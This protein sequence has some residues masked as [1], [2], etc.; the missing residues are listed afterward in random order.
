MVI[1]DKTFTVAGSRERV[2]DYLTKALMRSIPFE[3]IE[4]SDERGFSAGLKLKIGYFA[5]PA[6]VR[7]D[8]AKMVEPETLASRINLNA[9]AGMVQLEQIAR[10]DV[11]RVDEKNTEVSVKI[12]TTRMSLLLR[13]VLLWKVK[14]FARASLDSVERLLKDWV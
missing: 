8:I 3:Q 5:L 10:F 4:F 11:K 12:E 13:T 1:A 2:W 7:V 14:S 9:M 6:K